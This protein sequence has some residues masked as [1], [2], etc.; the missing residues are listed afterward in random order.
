VK[1]KIKT[2]VRRRREIKTS[3]RMRRE[4]GETGHNATIK[5]NKKDEK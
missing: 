3:V 2:S 4:L 5:D 1:R